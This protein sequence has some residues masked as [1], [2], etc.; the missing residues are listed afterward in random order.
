MSTVLN[1]DKQINNL[2]VDNNTCNK[3]DINNLPWIEKYRPDNLNMIY[4]HKNIICALK[5]FIKTKSLPHLLFYGPSGTG[6]TSTIISCAKKMYKSYYPYMVLEFNASDE[7]GIDMVRDKIKTF[8]SSQN[9]FTSGYKLVI[10]DETDAMTYDAQKILRQIIERYSK[11]AR[12]CLICNHVYKI[13][14][15]LQSRCTKFRFSPISINNMYTKIDKIIKK[16]KI[17][18]TEKGKKAILKLCNGDLRRA[19]NILQSTYMT[20]NKITLSNV[21]GA[22]NNCTEK[23]ICKIIRWMYKYSYK[24]S[25]KKVINYKYKNGISINNLLVGITKFIVKSDLDNSNKIFLFN[26][27]SNIEYNDMMISNDKIQLGSIIGIIKQIKIK[28]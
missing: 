13:I 2:F 21:Y 25:Y 22:T 7:R 8:V 3:I 11:N 15:A 26:E 9:F 4:S 14:P 16:E 5:K 28:N 12:F 23:D 24:K 10:L 1:T 17:E 18:A 6:K 20:Y 27:L 19:I